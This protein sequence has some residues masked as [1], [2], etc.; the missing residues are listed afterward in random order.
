MNETRIRKLF[1]AMVM[2]GAFL[3]FQISTAADAP[4]PQAAVKDAPS[5]DA[6]G[7]AG[8]PPQDASATGLLGSANEIAR[9]LKD[10]DTRLVVIE[11]SVAGINGSLVPVGALTKPERV[12]ALLH[13][14]GD[15]AFDRARTL[16]LVASA[17][18]AVLIVLLAVALRW[19]L[20]RKV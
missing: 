1:A 2:A 5:K 20:R 8:A 11:K 17:C 10:I 15:M 12:T 13:E 6:P 3:P 9:E 4:P 16:I 19:G 7:K 14:A 18:A